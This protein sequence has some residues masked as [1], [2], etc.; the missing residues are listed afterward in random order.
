MSG[1]W[2]NLSVGNGSHHGDDEGPVS[3]NDDTPACA[4][5][6]RRKLRCSRETPVCSHC[7]RLGE[8]ATFRYR[9]SSADPRSATECVYNPKQRPGLKP[10]AVEALTRR[11]GKMLL[12]CT[13]YCLTSGSILRTDIVGYLRKSSP[14]VQR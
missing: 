12:D 5:C 9:F 1:S 14:T 6:K 10:G 4:S 2:T 7:L 3:V 8:Y 13:E 11:V